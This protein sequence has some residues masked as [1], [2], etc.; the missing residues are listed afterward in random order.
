M[1]GVV[2]EDSSTT[3][4]NCLSCS[5]G[6][7]ITTPLNLDVGDP[8]LFEPYWKKMGDKCRVVI[9]GNDFM[10]Y[11]FDPKSVCS[12]IHPEL[13][14]AIKRIHCLVGNA[15]IDDKYIVVGTGSTQLFQ[16]SWFALSPSDSS[17]PINVISAA[18][19]YSAYPDAAGFLRSGIYHWGG[20]A[21]LYDKDEPYIEIVTSPNNPDGTIRGPVV[22]S[23]SEGKLVHDFAYYWPQYTP[24]T[25]KAD[26]DVMLFTF[27][28]CTGHAGSRIGWAIVK[29]IE[30]AKKMTHFLYLSSVGA[31]K[32]SQIRAAKILG[33]LC[34]SY[35]NLGSQ[36][37]FEYGKC[38]M[39]ERWE[40]L[41]EV[42][43]KSNVFTL[44]KYPK[45]YCKFTNE[46]SETYPGRGASR[47]KQSVT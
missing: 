13:K 24:I 45:A 15:V 29:D 25:H 34:D 35:Q 21:K 10:S 41:R 31:S 19:Y 36:P 8:L 2:V 42:F 6:T 47:T 30:V 11:G 46:T 1:G 39:R 5:N 33:V 9:E 4:E 3:N 7:T 17:N 26:H 38:L 14:D 37:F 40:K 22:R 12:F 18:P 43:E 27:S 44:A 16:A 23:K 32:E 20:D 28:K